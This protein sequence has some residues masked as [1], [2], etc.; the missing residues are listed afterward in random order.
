MIAHSVSTTRAK[1]FLQSLHRQVSLESLFAA[2]S[3]SEECIQ[4]SE[5]AL[6]RCF[7]RT[8]V[9]LGPLKE[10]ATLLDQVRWVH[11]DVP[12]FENGQ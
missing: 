8:T 5:T 12:L 4:E 1:E 2:T 6:V 11:G 3:T 9:A 7:P 10:T